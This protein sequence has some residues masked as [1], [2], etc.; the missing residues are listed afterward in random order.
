MPVTVK[1][2]WLAV[3]DHVVD[4][5]GRALYRVGTKL[6]FDAIAIGVGIESRLML[7]CDPPSALP[8]ANAR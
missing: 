4:L 8:T 6:P 2:R 3:L 5:L 7:S 1:E